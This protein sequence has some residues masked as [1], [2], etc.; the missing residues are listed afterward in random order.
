MNPDKFTAVIGIECGFV[1]EPYHNNAIAWER[2]KVIEMSEDPSASAMLERCDSREEVLLTIPHDV[3]AA[4]AI[5]ILT[6]WCLL[7]SVSSGP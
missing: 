3:F 6:R 5:R 1:M 7:P 4:M 2:A